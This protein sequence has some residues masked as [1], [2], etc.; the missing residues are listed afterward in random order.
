MPAISMP[1]PIP[2]RSKT[3]NPGA[4]LDPKSHKFGRRQILNPENVD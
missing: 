4:C 3:N 1:L 2:W